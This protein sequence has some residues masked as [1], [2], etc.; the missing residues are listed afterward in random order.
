M[1]QVVRA[2]MPVFVALVQFVRCL[3]PPSGKQLVV[4]T[5]ISIGVMCVVYQ[6]NIISSQSF[7]VLLVSASLIVQA[8]QMSFAGSLL[9]TKLD[10]F[11]MTFYTSPV[12]FLTL[13]GP[14]MSMEGATFQTYAMA[15]PDTTFLILVGTCLMAVFYNV[16]LFQT[17]RHLGAVGSSVLGNVKVVILIILSSVL[18]GEMRSWEA[19]HYVGCVLTFGGAAAYQHLKTTQNVPAKKLN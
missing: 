12:A 8:A 10:S 17:I 1:N 6:P 3:E 5:M 13:I 4:L 11:Q 16:V 15:R 7:G 14:A 18:M 9:S 19:R 2:T